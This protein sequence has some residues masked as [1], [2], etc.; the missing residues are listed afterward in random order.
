MQGLLGF[1]FVLFLWDQR[2]RGALKNMEDVMPHTGKFIHNT[3]Q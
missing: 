2:E 3:I 1:S